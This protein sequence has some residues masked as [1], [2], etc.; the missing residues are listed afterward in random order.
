VGL[1]VVGFAVMRLEGLGLYMGFPVVGLSVV[2]L[3]HF[4]K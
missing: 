3:K 4:Y 1:A 2:G